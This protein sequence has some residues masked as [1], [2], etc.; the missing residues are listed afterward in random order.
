MTHVTIPRFIAI[1]FLLIGIFF[2]NSTAAQASARVVHGNYFPT[3]AYYGNAG[4]SSYGMDTMYGRGYGNS[5]NYDDPYSYDYNL[6]PRF[7]ATL[8]LGNSYNNY[9]YQSDYYPRYGGYGYNDYYDQSP[10]GCDFYS[11]Y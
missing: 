7:S 6:T 5:Y 9:G 2:F 11:G 1:P 10:C 4:Y 3:N 8:F